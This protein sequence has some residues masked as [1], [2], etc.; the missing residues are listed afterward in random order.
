MDSPFP[1]RL[2]LTRWRPIIALLPV[3]CIIHDRQ[4]AYYAALGQADHAAEATS[5]LEFMLAAILRAIEES[6]LA[7]DQGKVSEKVSE[8]IVALLESD[9]SLS[10]AALATQIG[11]SPRTIE[12]GLRKLR[13]TRVIER[14]GPAKGGHW[15][16]REKP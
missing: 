15:V 4:Q 11:K 12:R 7:S 2:I 13:E 1:C 16:V 3:E 9:G 10:S 6:A 8:K 5:F 14:I